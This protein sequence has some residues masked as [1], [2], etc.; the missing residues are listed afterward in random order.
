LASPLC[1][2]S[3]YT[4][5]LSSEISD[6]NVAAQSHIVG[7]IPAV[8]VGIVVD[9]NVVAVP[10]PVIAITDIKSRDAKKESAEPEAARTASA[11]APPVT[12]AEAAFK[13]TMLPRMIEMEARIIAPVV[14]PDPLAVVMDMGG[15][16]MS[17]AFA[18]AGLG[19][20][21][22]R[23]GAMRGRWTVFRNIAAADR[24]AA[25]AAVLRPCG[26]SNFMGGPP[27]HT[28][29]LPVCE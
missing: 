11:K 28:L 13:V 26:Q 3:K 25:M 14:V 17:F 4:G 5:E 8:V 18:E 15:F 10:E 21:W 19:R 22:A 1:S 2:I 27:K 29:P 9:H 24:V 7:E 20:G 16:G 12:G 6:V 23:N